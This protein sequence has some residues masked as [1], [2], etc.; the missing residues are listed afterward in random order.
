MLA[1]PDQNKPSRMS[2]RAAFTL[3]ELLAVI[4]I[5]SIL[6]ALLLPAVQSSREA[7]RRIKCSNNLRQISLG[8]L[9]FESARRRIPHNGWGYSWAAEP[10]RSAGITQ[11][12][13]W[14]YQIL[15][16]LEANNIWS[17]GRGQ[18][19]VAKDA[20]INELLATP[21]A[22]F[23]CPTRATDQLGP[24]GKGVRY[25]NANPNTVART[26]Y[27]INEGDWIS[28]TPRGP[29]TLA[30]GDSRQFKWLDTSK[31]TG[32][33]AV[34]FGARL[35][36]ITDGTSNTY[37][38]GEKHVG[39]RSYAAGDDPGY[40]QSMYSGVDV[41]V[42]RW[43]IFPP[44]RDGET[45]LSNARRFGSA[46]ASAFHMAWCDGSVKGLSYQIDGKV[47]RRSGNRRDGT[48]AD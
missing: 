40:D 31:V 42:S 28:N 15:P 37:L 8:L 6:V 13:G 16:Q 2:V 20:A 46:H 17:I 10:D 22:T 47:H 4:G 24:R 7:A 5:I 1:K 39:R 18:S 23:V 27:A 35:A 44:M 43:T 38:I 14:I 19:G 41:D 45:S 3:I 33:S 12:A 32:V 26:D 11:P 21:L 29:K 25:F 9:N 48:V 34:R 30:E 36:E